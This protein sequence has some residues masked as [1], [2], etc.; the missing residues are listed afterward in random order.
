MAKESLSK[1]R[2]L[3]SR[4]VC[5]YTLLVLS[6]LSS[7][8]SLAIPRPAAGLDTDS[9]SDYGARSKKR[10]RFGQLELRQSHRN[11]KLADYREEGGV[12][13]GD[14]FEDD[15][16]MNG[17]G[18]TY[19]VNPENAQYEEEHEIELV[20]NH[21]RDEGREDDPEDLWMDNIVR[22]YF[23]MSTKC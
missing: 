11:G 9:D 2:S 1:R 13:Y 5:I 15:A 23:M 8:F 18:S 21:S 12:H 3:P 4:K 19:Y 14:D 10:K 17:E 16:P 6:N 20:L 22:F 7:L